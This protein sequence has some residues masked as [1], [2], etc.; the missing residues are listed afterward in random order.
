MLMLCL[1]NYIC[2]NLFL[3][4]KTKRGNIFYY[5]ID[6]VRCIAFKPDNE[7]IFLIGTEEGII[8]KCTTEYSSLFLETYEAHDTPVYNISWSTYITSI[9][10]TCAAEWLIKIWDE[11]SRYIYTTELG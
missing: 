3:Y 7:E 2:A 9:F 5:F 4:P 1:F 8:Y 6:G 11:N 10:I